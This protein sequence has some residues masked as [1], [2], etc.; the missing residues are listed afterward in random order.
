MCIDINNSFNSSIELPVFKKQESSFPTYL[1][2]IQK[3]GTLIFKKSKEIAAFP[4]RYLGS[5]TWSLPGMIRR[6]FTKKE[7]P[8]S[9]YHVKMEKKLTPDEVRGYLKYMAIAA[10]SFKTDQKWLEGVEGFRF[11]IFQRKNWI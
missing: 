10:A 8:L 1:Q 11:R 5:K 2:K 4:C 7:E 3:V 6:V 9:G